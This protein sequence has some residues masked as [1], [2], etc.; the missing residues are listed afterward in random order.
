MHFRYGCQSVLYTLSLLDS[1]GLSKY[2]KWD[3][4]KPNEKIKTY[5]GD[6]S[7]LGRATLNITVGLLSSDVQ[8][9][10]FEKSNHPDDLLT[11]L[12]LIYLFRLGLDPNMNVFQR[13]EEHQPDQQI[14]TNYSFPELFI[15]LLKADE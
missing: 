14:T 3:P 1:L 10:V 15:N 13:F 2:I 5:T 6:S 8:L 4:I 12:D 7:Y 11:G 9:H